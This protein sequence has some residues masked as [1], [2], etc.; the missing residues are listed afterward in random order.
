M[1]MDRRCSAGGWNAG[2]SAVDGAALNPHVDT[3][4]IALLAIDDEASLNWLR[5]VA[6]QSNSVYTLAWSVLALL[7]H[8]TASAECQVCLQRLRQRLTVDSGLNQLWLPKTVL[9]SDFIVS[10]PKIKTHHWAGVTLSMKNMFGIVPGS[11]Y[12]WPKD[13]SALGRHSRYFALQFARTSSSPTESSGRVGM[14]GSFF[15]TLARRSLTQ[16]I[17][18]VPIIV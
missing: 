16:S 10:M 7:R 6:S 5:H 18:V 3:T 2:N 13:I 11:R 14:P 1:L 9:S 4:A 8:K 17:I 15:Y 12:G